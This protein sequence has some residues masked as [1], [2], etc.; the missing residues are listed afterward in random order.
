MSQVDSRW[1]CIEGDRRTT[2]VLH[3]LDELDL[4][5]G[6]GEVV[7]VTDDFGLGALAHGQNHNVGL[8]RWSG[9]GV[10]SMPSAHA[11]ASWQYDTD[12]AMYASICLKLAA[13]HLSKS[14]ATATVSEER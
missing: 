1:L 8:Y 3:G 9:D 5:R 7:N 2:Y 10:S 11:R 4:R 14:Q 6:D 12:A 13:S